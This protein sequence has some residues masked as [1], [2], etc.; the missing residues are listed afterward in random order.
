MA[1]DPLAFF[2]AL[3]PGDPNEPLEVLSLVNAF[4]QRNA[5]CALVCQAIPD[6]ERSD[7]GGDQ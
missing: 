5:I 2:A 7:D 1:V 3:I 4:H 6:K